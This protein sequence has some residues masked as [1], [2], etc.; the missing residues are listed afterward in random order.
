MTERWNTRKTLLQRAQ[1]QDDPDAWDE[2]VFYYHDFLKMILIKMNFN[3]S[4]IED[5]IQEVLIKL[6]KA[7]PKFST[8]GSAKFRTWMSRIIRN[9]AIDYYRKNNKHDNEDIDDHNLSSIEEPEIENY[10]Q[11]EWEVHIIAL[12]LNSIK[13]LFSE[14]AMK[15]FDMAMKNKS[16]DEIALSLDITPN[17]ALKLKNRVK[18]RMVQEINA[19]RQKLEYF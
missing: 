8:E 19:L 17:A 3:Q 16:T 11:E 5:A 14:N 2:F 4:D 10:I 6:W 13:P 18:H 7:L 15:V 12:A 9:S 1:D